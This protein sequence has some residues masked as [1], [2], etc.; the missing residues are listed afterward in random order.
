MDTILPLDWFLRPIIDFEYKSLILAAYL[1][2]LD[3]SY[4]LH[5]LSPYLFWTEKLVQDM[6][7]FE[8]EFKE[9]DSSL[10]REIVGFSWKFGIVYE[11]KKTMREIEDI[12]EL[13]DYSVPILE[14]KIQQGYKLNAKFPQFLY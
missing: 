8:K 5:K 7:K 14:S 11:E 2:K 13:I 12:M 3:V 1:Q 9:F 10:K 6:K 4:S